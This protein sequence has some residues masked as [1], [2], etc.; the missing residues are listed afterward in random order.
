MVVQWL[1]LWTFTTHAQG[2]GLGQETNIPASLKVWGKKENK[3][4][5]SPFQNI[6]KPQY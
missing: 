2:S 4:T 5:P 6:I 1:G 3:T